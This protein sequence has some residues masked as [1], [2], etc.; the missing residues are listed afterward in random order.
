[1]VGWRWACQLYCQH[2]NKTLTKSA[3]AIQ[4]QK[5]LELITDSPRSPAP[6]PA[7]SSG[8]LQS[9]MNSSESS[10]RCCQELCFFHHTKDF[11]CSFALGLAVAVHTQLSSSI[12]KICIYWLGNSQKTFLTSLNLV[13]VNIRACQNQKSRNYRGESGMT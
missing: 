1:M 13:S 8:N 12:R 3:E 5:G 11:H 6:D 10:A 9:L 7:I 2:D 4:M